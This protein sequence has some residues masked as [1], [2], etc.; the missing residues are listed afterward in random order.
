[1]V[2]G[3][4]P[5]LV[6]PGWSTVAAWIDDFSSPASKDSRY[7]EFSGFWDWLKANYTITWNNGHGV[8]TVETPDD[9]IRHRKAEHRLAD[10]D[11]GIDNPRYHCEGVVKAYYKSLKDKGLADKSRREYVGTVT[12][13]FKH[14]THDEH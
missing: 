6:R 7:F 11:D 3:K 12:T 14:A 2:Q 13:W 1:M 4:Y 10:D 8:A 5:N 9:L